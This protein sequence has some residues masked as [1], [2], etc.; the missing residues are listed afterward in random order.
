MTNRPLGTIGDTVIFENEHVRI[1][2]LTLEPGERQAWHVH[3]L[4][5]IVIPLTEGKN[6][7]RW[8]DGKVVHTNEMPGQALW[9]L[10]GGVHELL[11]TSGWAYRNLL[12]EIKNTGLDKPHVE[13]A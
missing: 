13:T 6:E 8:E 4:P 2:G 9:R 12:I 11:N 7:M 1:W 5:Y 3:E 10:P